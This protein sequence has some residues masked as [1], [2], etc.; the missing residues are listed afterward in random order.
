[1]LYNELQQLLFHKLFL[2]Q[3]NSSISLEVQDN[4][5]LASLKDGGLCQAKCTLVQYQT[6]DVHPKLQN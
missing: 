5:L 3:Q 1:M 6:M 2:Y 4:L